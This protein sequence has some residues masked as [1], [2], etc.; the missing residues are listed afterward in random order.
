MVS[1]K[2]QDEN[3]VILAGR[4]TKDAVLRYTLNNLAVVR[5]TI[6]VNTIVKD[7]KETLF[8]PVVAYGDLAL[9]VSSLIK[10]GTPVR[11]EGRLVNRVVKFSEE[12]EHKFVE[13][14]AH[15]IEIYN[16]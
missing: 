4:L 15:K 7:K 10:Q 6:A 13:V 12:E 3:K 8:I 16:K 2:F 9:E 14:V 11:V 1:A 5:F